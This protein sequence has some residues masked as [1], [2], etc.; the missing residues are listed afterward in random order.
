MLGHEDRF[1]TFIYKRLGTH[2]VINYRMVNMIKYSHR[3]LSLL[4]D[5]RTLNGLSE[6]KVNLYLV[7]KLVYREKELLEYKL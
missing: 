7:N 4:Q 5:Y 1:K 2:V 6:L 3:Y